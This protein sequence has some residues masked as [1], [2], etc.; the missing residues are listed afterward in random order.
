MIL[1]KMLSWG[2]G[3]M[4]G[5]FLFFFTALCGISLYNIWKDHND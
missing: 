4:A 2:L 3:A 5:V 1:L